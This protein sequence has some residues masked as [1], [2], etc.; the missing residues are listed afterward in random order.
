M[1]ALAVLLTGSLAKIPVD[2]V[3]EP[4]GFKSPKHCSVP[5]YFPFTSGRYA[6]KRNML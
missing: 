6:R 4:S 5:Q 3:I 1:D 2:N